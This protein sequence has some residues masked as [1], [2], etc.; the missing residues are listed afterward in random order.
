MGRGNIYVAGGFK[1]FANYIRKMKDRSKINHTKYAFATR[2]PNVSFLGF[3]VVDVRDVT[4]IEWYNLMINKDELN[5]IPN[6]LKT[7]EF[8]EYMKKENPN[9][10]IGLP[11]IMT[12]EQFKE[13]YPGV[14]IRLFTEDKCHNGHQW[15]LGLNKCNTF[16][17]STKCGNGLYFIYEGDKEKWLTYNG[18]VMYWYTYVIIPDYTIVAV[19]D[20]DDIKFKAEEIIVP[21]F[22]KL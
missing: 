11:K 6:S 18:K 1:I 20:A 10:D 17:P 4:A 16:N 9:A 15:E 13:Y 14:F 3:T 12:G 5:K 7:P 8:I 21:E 2:G 19:I 22:I